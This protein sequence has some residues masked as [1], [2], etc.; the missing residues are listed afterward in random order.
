MHAPLTPRPPLT[1][2]QVQAIQSR[3]GRCLSDL[4]Q[5]PQ[6][7]HDAAHAADDHLVK[8]VREVTEKRGQLAWA[9]LRYDGT[10]FVLI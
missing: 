10:E 3:R 5:I 9:A 8:C 2:P 4:S 1:L 7:L 6:H